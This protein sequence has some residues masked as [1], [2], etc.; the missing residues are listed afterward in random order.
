MTFPFETSALW[1]ATLGSQRKDHLRRAR[2]L[3]RVSFISFRSNVEQLVA[4]IR[5]ELRWLTVHDITHLDALWDVADQIVGAKYPLNPA[6]AYVLGGAFLLHD[7]GHTLAAYPNGMADIKATDQWKDLIAQQYAGSDPQPGSPEEK[8]ALFQVLRDLHAEQARTLAT[9]WSTPDPQN[10]APRY[11]IESADLRNHYADLIGEI[12]ASHH[13][14]AHQVA[15]AFRDRQVTCPA[16]LDSADWEVDALKVALILR[17]ADAAHLD[18]RRAPWFLFALQQPQG[19]SLEH[20]RFQAKLGKP[21]LKKGTEEL[22]LTSGSKFNANEREA[23]WLAF[24]TA[25]MVDRELRSAHAILREEKRAPFTATRVLGVESSEAFAKQVP[26]EGWEPINTELKVGNIKQLITRLGGSALY[27]ND[28]TAP[29]RELLQNALDAVRALRALGGL[30][31]EEGEVKVEVEPAEN[32]H[33]WLKVT[34]TGIGMSRHVLTDVLLDFGTSLWSSDILRQ[35]LPGLAAT[36]F[37]PVGKFGIGFFSVFMLGD[38]VKVTTRRHEKSGH[39]PDV[40]WQLRF[41]KGLSSRPILLEPPKNERLERSGTCVT[42]KLSTQA[43]NGL[44]GFTPIR[45]TTIEDNYE[46][47][48]INRVTRLCPMS[49][50]K[51]ITR[52]CDRIHVTVVEANDWIKINDKAIIRRT[53]QTGVPIYFEPRALLPLYDHNEQIMGRI[54]PSYHPFQSATITHQGLA[55]G[56]IRGLI[57]LVQARSNNADARRKQNIPG[58]DLTHWGKWAKK[59]IDNSSSLN[60]HNIIALHALLPGR[61]MPVWTLGENEFTLEELITR[62]DSFNCLFLHNGY[63]AHDI[64]DSISKWEFNKYFKP[65]SNLIIVPDFHEEDEFPWSIGAGIINYYRRLSKALGENWFRAADDKLSVVG[66]VNGTEIYRRV[67][68]LRR[69]E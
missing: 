47:S 60:N 10:Q 43:W 21:K 23:W 52:F 62:I 66:E 24:D 5:S 37:G 63:I 18:G 7:A 46:Q 61:D 44:V 56:R 28:R 68:V 17:T 49:S 15:T 40:H 12:A 9:N 2:E 6:E 13:W 8:T 59:V 48:L 34:D 27:G 58:G 50:V 22:M 65:S 51:I 3:L 16:C 54:A 4:D 30:G 14:P 35:E 41:D 19:I 39:D 25:R 67:E 53:C 69:C 42:V 36:Q 45:T 64:E 20:W 31:P 29:L 11:L 1:K 55:S 33:W 32:D 26:V 57:G 38:E